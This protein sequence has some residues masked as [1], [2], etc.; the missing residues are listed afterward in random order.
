MRSRDAIALG[1]DGVLYVH[2]TVTGHNSLYASN[3]PLSHD[4]KSR[5]RQTGSIRVL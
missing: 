1:I 4:G 5:Q 2:Y 3:M